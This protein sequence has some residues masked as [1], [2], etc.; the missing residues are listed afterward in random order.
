MKLTTVACL[1]LLS[2]PPIF[3]ASVGE[4]IGA[5]SDSLIKDY[6]QKAGATKTTLAV[7]PF[8]S[9]PDLAKK[10]YGF[11]VSEVMSHRLAASGLFTMVERSELNR[12]LEEQR[13]GAS[14]VV[15]NETA[16]RIGKILG[17]KLIL[18]GSVHKL[19]KKY[20]VNAR[21]VDPESSEVLSSAYAELDAEVFESETKDYALLV[22]EIQAIGLYVLY[23]FRH[24]A[25]DFPD[26]ISVLNMPGVVDTTTYKPHSFYSKL[27]GLGLRYSPSRKIQ[28]DLAAAF[29]KR[30][31]S[32]AVTRDSFVDYTP[33]PDYSYSFEDSIGITMYRAM[34]GYKG[35]LSSKLKYCLSGGLA[36]YAFETG[37]ES[38]NT[39]L[40][41]ARLEYFPQRRLGLSLSA[42]YDLTSKTY[43]VDGSN[44]RIALVRLDR[45]YIEP[46]LALY[47]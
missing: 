2:F 5:V 35:G 7:F 36:K 38:Y 34:I 21:L 17:A 23:N 22:P 8:T 12:V 13:L 26:K 40:L 1:L 6:R 31:G 25:N 20:Q 30:N 46:S 19:G 28:V 37:K 16:V 10:R 43:Y 4:R 15:E 14:G 18:A 9:E 39:P 42:G 41:H 27:G 32:K 3:A 33:D 11:A 45:V 47:F 44:G 29:S 24:N